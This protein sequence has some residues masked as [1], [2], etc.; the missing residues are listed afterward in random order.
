MERIEGLLEER[1]KN[2]LLRTLKPA[3]FR[4]KGCI[5]LKGKK[6]LDFSSNDYLG[7]SSHPKLKQASQEA[8]KKFGTSSSASR[9][10][11]GDLNIFHKLEK[12][13]C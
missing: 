8:I 10:L 7:L 11:S 12:K 6:Y 2:S 9:L 1:K 13:S 3:E 4:A 5:Y